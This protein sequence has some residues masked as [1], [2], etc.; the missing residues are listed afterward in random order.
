METL[1]CGPTALKHFEIQITKTVTNMNT[2]KSTRSICPECLQALDAEIYEDGGKVF[3]KKTCPQH[4]AFQELYWSDYDQYVRAEKFRFDGEGIENPRTQK[5]KGCPLD[6]GICPEHKSHTA[7]SHHRRDEP[8]Q[9][10]MPR[11]LRQR[12]CCR[13]RLR[14]HRRTNHGYAGEPACNQTCPRHGAAVQRRRTHH[15]R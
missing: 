6:C 14:T 12:L 2:I 15:P 4:G 5:D 8:M 7:S 3:I 10:Q 13:I 1:L 9:P 11:L